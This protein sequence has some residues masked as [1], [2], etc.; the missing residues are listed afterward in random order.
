MKKIISICLLVALG[1]AACFAQ[2][3]ALSNSEFQRWATKYEPSFRAVKAQ[4][5]IES[6]KLLVTYRYDYVVD[7]L[8]GHKI[9]YD[10][11]LLE[12]GAQT[13]KFYGRNAEI[14][15]SLMDN[16]V[17]SSG[18]TL[19]GA[20]DGVAYP[21]FLGENETAIYNDIY[22]YPKA[23]ERLVST[24]FIQLDYQY[25]EP[26]NELSWN[27]LP[28]TETVLGYLCKK[29]ET[30]F[31]GRKWYA[32][33]AMELP[34]N[35]GPWKLGGLPGLILKAEDVDGL[36]KWQA[37]GI[38]QPDNRTIYAYDQ[39]ALNNKGNDFI[40]KYKVKLCTRKEVEKLWK[41]QWLAPLSMKFLDGR[42]AFVFAKDA[43]GKWT[44][45]AVDMTMPDSYY[46]RLE[47]D[48]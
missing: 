15:D 29:A 1:T 7:T 13:T 43:T 42:E 34:Y 5:A 46:P 48:M 23:N 19:N 24:R 47:L 41:R 11:N 35:F 17:N 40:P 31:R 45:V 9:Y 27:V 37:V 18:N 14:R 3:K 8:K 21:K 32:W 16:T 10:F 12:I 33:F 6:C 28:Q 36:F 26:I 30:E 38:E 25:K 2:K 20:S 44:K 4:T 39:K 22:T